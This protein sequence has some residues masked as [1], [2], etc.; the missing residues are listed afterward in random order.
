MSA[1]DSLPVPSPTTTVAPGGSYAF[2]VVYEPTSSGA[3]SGTLT[4]A[5]AAGNLTAALSGTGLG[6][7]SQ[8][9]MR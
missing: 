4:V 7:P 3:D 5:T 9:T 8:V 6:Q 2:E 1:S